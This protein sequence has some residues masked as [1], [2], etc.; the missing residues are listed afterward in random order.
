MNR[1]LSHSLIVLLIAAIICLLVALLMYGG[2]PFSSLVEKTPLD[3]LVQVRQSY[4]V[5][6]PPLLSVGFINRVLSAYHSPTAGLWRS[7]S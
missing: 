2:K 3:S 7:L 4:A 1:L 6:R 5:D